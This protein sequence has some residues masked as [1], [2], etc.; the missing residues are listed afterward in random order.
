MVLASITRGF[1]D[2]LAGRGEPVAGRVVRTMVPVSVRRAE[3]SGGVYNNRVSAMFAELPVGLADPVERLHDVR[4]QMDGLKESNQA[5]AGEVLTSLGGF[6]PALL[7]D[8]GTRL[9]MRTPQQS[10]ET[11]TTNV[12]GPQYPL[13]VGGRRMLDSFPY[14]PLGGRIRQAIAIFSYV[15][16]LTF[17]VTA[18]AD[19]VPDLE[20]LAHGIEEGLAELLKAAREVGGSAARGGG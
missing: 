19:H 10:I 5:V 17:G 6:A 3:E 12:P 1:R 14:V 16:R 20:V 2:L 8:L 15:G 13:Y 18:D 7:L 11:I 4:V 9:A